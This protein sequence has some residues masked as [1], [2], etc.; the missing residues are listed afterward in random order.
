MKE[1]DFFYWFQGAFELVGV[2]AISTS[3]V[4]IVLNHIALVLETDHLE[5]QKGI[6]PPLSENFQAIR[7]LVLD[8]Q[9]YKDSR[10]QIAV[11]IQKTLADQFQHVIDP[12]FGGPE[13]Q[14]KLNAAHSVGGL[15]IGGTGP[16]GEV[17]R[18]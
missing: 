9:E 4:H 1:R 3:N 5:A 16:N 11:K 6:T 14:E 15:S 13:V 10:A 7:K 8:Y 2:T 12:S 18:C 17:Y